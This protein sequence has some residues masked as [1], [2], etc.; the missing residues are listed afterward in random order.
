MKLI[1]SILSRLMKS[2]KAEPAVTAEP[3]PTKQLRAEIFHATGCNHRVF[4]DT[5]RADYEH[6]KQVA[7]L[8][9]RKA[10]D[11][12]RL[13]DGSHI[14]HMPNLI[15]FWTEQALDSRALVRRVCANKDALRGKAVVAFCRAVYGNNMALRFVMET[16]VEG[17]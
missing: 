4:R 15:L 10:A 7:A 12:H 3:V 16:G 2:K 1:Q 11:V 5:G 9:G 6:A 8:L 14:L 13:E 17:K